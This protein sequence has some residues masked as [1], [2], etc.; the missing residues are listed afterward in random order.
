MLKYAYQYSTQLQEV[1]GEFLN[2]PR[3]F[4]WNNGSYYDFELELAKDTYNRLDYVSVNSIGEIIGYMSCN[5][6]REAHF[7][8]GLNIIN[9]TGD[10]TSICFARDLRQLF[11]KLFIDMGMNKIV[12]SVVIGNKA[13]SMYDR[14]IQRYGGKVV[15][16]FI[17]DVK[18]SDGK[19]Y[20]RKH[21]E[22]FKH[23]YLK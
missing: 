18:L 3:S 2:S 15:G 9:F 14:F 16:T 1:Y 23:E 17:Q 21:Y 8:H 7:I 5:I 12:F 6:A 22:I 19:L 10:G 13:E 4:Y 11:N 20:D